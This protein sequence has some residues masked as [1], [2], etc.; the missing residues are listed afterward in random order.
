MNGSVFED[1][2]FGKHDVLVVAP[3]KLM[4][5]CTCHGAQNR[6]DAVGSTNSFE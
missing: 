4:C 3:N 6:L 2:R 1:V 5:S